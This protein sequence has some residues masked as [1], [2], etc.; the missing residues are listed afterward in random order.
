MSD[1]IGIAT[2]LLQ[3]NILDE[4]TLYEQKINKNCI[5][6]IKGDVFRQS[7]DDGKRGFILNQTPRLVISE[8]SS[9]VG[10]P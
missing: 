1:G 7:L 4:L 5:I 2:A 8:V 6:I 9:V 3:K 10:E